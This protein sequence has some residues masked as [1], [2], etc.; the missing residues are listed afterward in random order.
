MKVAVEHETSVCA[1]EIFKNGF[2]VEEQR[3]LAL[4]P[5]LDYLLPGNAAD[6]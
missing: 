4:V 2:A 5:G 1:E 6:R 3:E